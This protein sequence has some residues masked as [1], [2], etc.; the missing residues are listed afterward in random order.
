MRLRGQIE[1]VDGIIDIGGEVGSI[2]E[3]KLPPPEE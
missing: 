2:V 3:R 1:S